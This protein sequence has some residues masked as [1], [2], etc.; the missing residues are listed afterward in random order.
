M[1][2]EIRIAPPELDFVLEFRG[3]IPASTTETVS[4]MMDDIL[5][6]VKA[7]TAKP[8]ADQD[9]SNLSKAVTEKAMKDT[10]SSLANLALEQDGVM[11]QVYTRAEIEDGIYN[12]TQVDTLL[13][14]ASNIAGRELGDQIRQ[15]ELKMEAKYD[16]LKRELC[17]KLA[18]KAEAQTKP[19]DIETG[20][21]SD[22][23]CIEVAS[24]I[25]ILLRQHPELVLI[26]TDSGV[27]QLKEK[28][29]S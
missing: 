20:N 15:L 21:S 26:M 7:D 10:L 2:T 16:K 8:K 11:K 13:R 17:H 24:K 25:N 19:D 18:G 4:G 9:L 23:R 12:K 29:K 22:I 5:L 14:T 27:F 1:K 3:N 6:F 28:D